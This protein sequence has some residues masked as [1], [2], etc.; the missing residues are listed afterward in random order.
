MDLSIYMIIS[1][2]AIF[3]TGAAVALAWG[4]ADGQWKDTSRTARIVLD[5]DDP[6][7]GQEADDSTMGA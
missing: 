1:T 5:F 6:Y 7:P 2:F 3:F 4:F